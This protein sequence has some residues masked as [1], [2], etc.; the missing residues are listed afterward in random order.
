MG[1]YRQFD[2]FDPLDGFAPGH[3]FGP[4]PSVAEGARKLLAGRTRD[5]LNFSDV[6]RNGPA[7]RRTPQQPFPRSNTELKATQ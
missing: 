5:Q 6:K 4:L 1:F 7:M 2:E 3:P